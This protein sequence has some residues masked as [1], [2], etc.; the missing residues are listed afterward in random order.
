MLGSRSHN[1]KRK[2]SDKGK[3][4]ESYVTFDR[5]LKTDLE[6]SLPPDSELQKID[7]HIGLNTLRH[8]S[9]SLEWIRHSPVSRDPTPYPTRDLT[10]YPT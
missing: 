2:L 1:H 6:S 10:S 4:K 5:R 8:L 7:F 3:R 9:K